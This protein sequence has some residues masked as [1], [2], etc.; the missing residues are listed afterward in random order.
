M[1]T[2]WHWVGEIMARST[3]SGQDDRKKLI[4]PISMLGQQLEGSGSFHRLSE[5]ER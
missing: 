5:T 1:V 3:T 4:I 2:E